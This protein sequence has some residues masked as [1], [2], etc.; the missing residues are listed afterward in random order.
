MLGLALSIVA[1]TAGRPVF[2][3]VCGIL[4]GGLLARAA[5]GH[6]GIKAVLQGDAG[7][8]ERLSQAVDESGEESFPASDP[9]SSHL[10]DEP[11][12]NAAAKWAAARVAGDVD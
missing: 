7:P 10:P 6:C 5:A 9:P 4:A 11:P 2:R 12:S 1:L 8:G 3:A